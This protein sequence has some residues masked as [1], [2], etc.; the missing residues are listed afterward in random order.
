M[1]QFAGAAGSP[2]EPAPAPT[3]ADGFFAPTYRRNDLRNW[4]AKGSAALTVRQWRRRRAG[5]V[6]G[7]PHGEAE[8]VSAVIFDQECLS[9]NQLSRRPCIP[10]ASHIRHGRRNP[11]KRLGNG[12]GGVTL[13]TVSKRLAR[14]EQELIVGRQSRAIRGVVQKH[15]PFTIEEESNVDRPSGEIRLLQPEKLLQRLVE[16]YRPP[17]VTAA[18][19]SERAAR[20]PEAQLIGTLPPGSRT[21]ERPSQLQ[22]RFFGTP[23]RHDLRERRRCRS[24]VPS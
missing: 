6:A 11:R 19:S 9:R 18:V 23:L 2:T 21:A 5:G 10:A 8:S 1:V 24:T 22:P 14:L 7:P 3:R 13:S 12:G 15:G 20:G 17:E 16:N 4:S